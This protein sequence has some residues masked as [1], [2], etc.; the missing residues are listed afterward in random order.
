MDW[1]ERISFDPD[2]CHG[3][4]CIKGR[5]VMVSVILDNV[6]DHVEREVIKSEYHLEDA[7]IDAALHYAADLIRDQ[8][9]TLIPISHD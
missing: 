8:R 1:Q 9:M 5:R 7:D 3:Q 4:P 2:I 6:A